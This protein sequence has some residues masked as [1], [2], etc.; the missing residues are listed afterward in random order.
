MFV[1]QSLL[2]QPNFCEKFSLELWS[3]EKV[4]IQ[5]GKACKN[6]AENPNEKMVRKL[7]AQAEN[8]RNYHV[9]FQ[10]NMIPT[11]IQAAEKRLKEQ[12]ATRMTKWRHKKSE[13]SW[14]TAAL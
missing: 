14:A 8:V 10:R 1:T 5:I 6:R 3:G 13:R 12:Q 7:D 2:F 4:G 11:H 9:V